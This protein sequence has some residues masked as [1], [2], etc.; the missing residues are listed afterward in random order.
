M[1]LLKTKFAGWIWKKKINDGGS[2]VGE[3]D[4]FGKNYSPALW[5]ARAKKDAA[6]ENLVKKQ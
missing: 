3:I 6:Q 2:K 1:R 4:V 5:K